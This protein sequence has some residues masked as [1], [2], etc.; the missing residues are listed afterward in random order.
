MLRLAILLSTLLLASTALADH[1]HGP[2]TIGSTTSVAV[3]Y[4]DDQESAV[5]F[6][7]KGKTQWK[8]AVEIFE[9]SSS[10]HYPDPN[11]I[12]PSITIVG[13]IGEDATMEGGVVYRILHVT[14]PDRDNAV[15][16]VLTAN[17]VIQSNQ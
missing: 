5:D 6:L 9:A 11:S 8:A 12:A 13:Q 1:K 17:N 10:C 3:P 14:F 2:Y 7:E 4:C 16:Y 15:G